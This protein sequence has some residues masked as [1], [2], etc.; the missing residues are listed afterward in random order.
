MI[1]DTS[2]QDSVVKSRTLS[3]KKAVGVI[4]I[5]GTLAITAQVISVA[6]NT[7]RS[8]ERDAL[9]FATV[10]RGDFVRDILASGRIVAANAPQVYS[11][12]A[13]FVDLLVK[14][15]DTVDAGDVIA[16]VVSPALTNELKQQQAE[17]ARLQDGLAR[18]QLEVRRETLTLNRSLEL[19]KVTLDAAERE[20]R[21]A[22]LSIKK[23]LISQIDLEEAV[24]DLARAKLNYRHAQ[25][26]VALGKDTLAFELAAAS[27]LVERQQLVVDELQRKVN[28]LEINAPVSGLVG[29]LMVQTKAAVV[30]QQAL[31]TLVDLSA[32]EAQL[33][34]PE[35]YAN[36]LGLGMQVVLKVGAS[37]LYGKLSAISPEVS[38]REVTA[39]VR[40]E[41]SDIDGIRQN[42]R[43]SARIL[44][45]QK[46][47]VVKVRRGS[48]M[49]AGGSVVY[50]IQGEV[51][52]RMDIR[53]GASSVNEVE[54]LDGLSPG[55]QIIVSN[56]EQFEN[57][58]LV[59]LR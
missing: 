44:L 19:A 52:T 3:W 47:N 32:Y 33:Q 4:A 40:F 29:N 57:A 51:A 1:K 56:Y 14:A 38:N 2:K 26:E 24:D 13:G 53:T 8:F 58:P 20:N 46:E 25:Q 18:E 37:E 10:S 15:G 11:P 23:N 22:Q 41:H 36:E 9:Q 59:Q 43:L 12:E 54:I 28:A 48:F 39:R 55:D 50:R 35:S 49:N 34:V 7:G 5:C 45:D 30:A 16:R 31:M 6:D 27:N 17:L 42:Q 21:R